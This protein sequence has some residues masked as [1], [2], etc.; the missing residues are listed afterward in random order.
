MDEIKKIL[1][2]LGFSDY[3]QGIFNYADM[4]AD[5]LGA[6]LIVANII[7]SR[8][9]EA[10]TVIKNMGYDL[11]PERYI[12]EIKEERRKAFEEVSK[13]T[14]LAGDSLKLIVQVGNPADEL[15]KIIVR[16]NVD[17]VVMGVKGR[18]DLEHIF[19]GSVAEKLFRRSP[20]TVIS[21]RDEKN[22]ER[23]A[24]RIDVT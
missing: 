10:V 17:A 7:N 14:T 22:R 19:I 13:N 12:K 5:K 8:D 21:Y 1:V 4:L 2:A 3:A 18:T 23:L 15:L 11:D 9:V 6:E 16:E 20:V 24:K